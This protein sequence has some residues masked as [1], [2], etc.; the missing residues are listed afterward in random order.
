[1]SSLNSSKTAQSGRGGGASSSRGDSSSSSSGGH[2]T[3]TGNR[4]RGGNSNAT[5]RQGSKAGQAGMSAGGALGQQPLQA[6]SMAGMAPSLGGAG[7]VTPSKVPL[8]MEDDAVSSNADTDAHSSVSQQGAADQS[9]RIAQL[10]QQLREQAARL[11]Q[12]ALGS[13]AS[14]VQASGPSQW[15]QQQQQQPQQQPQQPHQQQQQ[16]PSQEQIVRVDAVRPP[17]LTYAGATA[18]TALE[19]WLFKLEQLFSQ[20]RKPESDWSGRSQLAQLHWDRHMAMWWTGRQEAAAA[21]GEPLH[22]WVAFV[23]ALRKQFVPAGDSQLARTELFKLKMRSGETMEAYM[24]RAVLLVTRAGGLM[25][26]KTAAALSLEGVDKSRFPFTCAAVARKERAAGAT[27]MS[28][29]QMREEL[30]VEAAMEPQL[31]GR[32]S[33]NSHSGGSSSSSSS[34]G[35]AKGATN[36]RQLRINALQ[37]Q[38]KALEEGDDAEDD[39]ESFGVAPIGAGSE[40]DGRDRCYKCGEQGHATPN[41]K[42]KKELRSCYHCRQPGHLKPECPK[43][44]KG[45]QKQGKGQVQGKGAGEAGGSAPGA[46]GGK[47][48]P[49]NE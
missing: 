40:H 1:M 19:D 3:G 11:E 36:T 5:P 42:S 29:A 24:Q 15:Q 39:E 16:Q 34:G 26:G 2:R 30:T 9:M 23:A 35:G 6:S 32:G 33:S 20:T 22:S 17:E 4:G 27:G 31:G 37:Q 28:F 49:K 8:P 13:S 21:A 45:A 12:L 48:A 7:L 44:H 38:L 43:L 46:A 10:E 14:A 47:P 41:C 25:E 18:G